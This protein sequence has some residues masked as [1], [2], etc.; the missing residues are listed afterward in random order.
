MPIQVSKM[1]GGKPFLVWKEKRYGQSQP[2]RMDSASSFAEAVKKAKRSKYPVTYILS[3]KEIHQ[4]KTA[5]TR[6]IRHRTRRKK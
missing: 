6:V 2:S 5:P 3:L 1:S 4:I